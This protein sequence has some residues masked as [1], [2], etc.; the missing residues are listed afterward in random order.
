MVLVDIV[1]YGILVVFA[2][3]VLFCF[4]GCTNICNPFEQLTKCG[5][6]RDCLDCFRCCGLTRSPQ[7]VRD[8]RRVA[9]AKA[10]AKKDGE[11][12]LSTAELE[13][14]LLLAQLTKFEN[15]RSGKFDRSSRRDLEEGRAPDE[16]E[17]V[18]PLKAEPAQSKQYQKKSQR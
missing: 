3:G 5:W 11:R 6:L 7:E 8:A 1:L 17:P 14:L 9:D 16:D 2:I 18:A 10:K 12:E 4:F 15:D 13:R